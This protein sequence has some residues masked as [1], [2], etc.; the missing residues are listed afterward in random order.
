MF[1]FRLFLCVGILTIWSLQESS[2]QVMLGAIQKGRASY[3][4]PSFHGKKTAFGETFK[5]TELSAAHPTYPL[6][7]MLEVTNLDNNEKVVVRVNDRGP[8]AK[9]RIIDLSKEAA[10]LLGIVSKGVANVAVRVVGMEGM[11]F[12]GMHED[13][14]VKTGK[15]ISLAP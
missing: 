11:I 12:L 10:K 13:A 2:A 5:T 4:A 15:I 14:D 1:K 3:Y 6:N 7:T 8:F 9:S